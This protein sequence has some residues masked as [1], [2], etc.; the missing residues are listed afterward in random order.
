[1]AA[2]YTYIDPAELVTLLDDEEKGGK[3][4]IVDCRD[5]DRG[6]GFIVG[7]IHFPS[8]TQSEARFAELATSLA[9]EGKTII[10]FHCALSQ[11]RGPK[12]ANRFASALR[13]QGMTSPV[14]HVL[15]GGWENFCALYGESRP[16]LMSE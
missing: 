16:D 11:V 1:M 10:V 5:D 4:A 2:S 7:S 9:Q 12:G 14:V 6:D 13:V 15:R 3:V 8:T